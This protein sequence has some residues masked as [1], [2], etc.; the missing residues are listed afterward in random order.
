MIESDQPLPC[1]LLLTKS[2]DPKGLCYVETKSLD[3]ETNLKHK[4]ANT[5]VMK[6]SQDE[7][8]ILKNF[9]TATI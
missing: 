2:S 6:I 7:H 4:Q 5:E 8:D 1:D 9:K 3:G